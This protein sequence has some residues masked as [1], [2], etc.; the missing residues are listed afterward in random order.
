MKRGEIWEIDFNPT[1]GSE[2]SKIR[3]AVII[4]DNNIGILSL[5]IVVP[6]T[7]WKNQFSE[8]SWITQ[9][10]PSK[11]NHLSKPSSAD[12][13]QVK[14]LSVNRFI[15][16]ICKVTNEEIDEIVAGVG[17]CIEY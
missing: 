13:F 5:K 16:K 3:P 4:S 17:I 1:Q 10:M 12:S 14:S 2:I 9:L 8:Y 6:I 15:R 7:N 11:T